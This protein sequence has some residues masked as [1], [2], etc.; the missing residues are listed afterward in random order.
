MCHT[1]HSRPFFKFQ[2]STAGHDGSW[3]YFS[4][5]SVPFPLRIGPPLPCPLAAVAAVWNEPQLPFNII[6]HMLQHATHLH[7]RLTTSPVT[8]HHRRQRRRQRQRQRHHHHQQRRA[9]QQ[10]G[11]AMP[12]SYASL[13]FKASHVTPVL[14]PLLSCCVPL[15]P[16]F[17]P[18]KCAH[19]PPSPPPPSPL[20]PA[21]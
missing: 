15:L 21:C 11:A 2:V 7:R 8:V 9:R 10:H 5:V 3:P 16:F 20:L 12:T 6:T 18:L 1:G 19:L 4:R 13:S 14:P 17:K